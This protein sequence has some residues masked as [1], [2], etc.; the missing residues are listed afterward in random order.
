MF[1]E[2]LLKIGTKSQILLPWGQN[3]YQIIE[4][5]HH[6]VKELRK[7]KKKGGGVNVL[8]LE[9]QNVNEN[10]ETILQF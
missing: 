10:K 2:V 9:L 1:W 7:I 4:F 5:I 3:H 6:M 8:V